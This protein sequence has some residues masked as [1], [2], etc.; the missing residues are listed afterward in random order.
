MARRWM[1][2]MAAGA[3][4][5]VAAASCSQSEPPLIDTSQGAWYDASVPYEGGSVGH[6]DASAEG[7]DASG[8][9]DAS[10]DGD[11]SMD[12]DATAD[13]EGRADGDAT[14]GGDATADGDAAGMDATVDGEATADGDATPTD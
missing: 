13:G 3:G 2:W 10:G 8:V 4:C 14:A 11:A 6:V 1:A 7:G 12:G 5:A 9:K